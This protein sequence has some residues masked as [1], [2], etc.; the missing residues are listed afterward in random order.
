MRSACVST[1]VSVLV[2]STANAAPPLPTG[3]HPRV[4]L[5]PGTVAAWQAMEADA[6]SPVGRAIATCEDAA[7]VPA[8]ACPYSDGEYQGFKWVEGLGAC[9]VAYATQGE[10]AQLDTALV[11]F[12]A[13]LNDRDTIGDGEGPG[14]NGGVGIVSQDTGYSMRTHG[15]WAALA[16]DWLYDD[17][18]PS[19]IATART[20][21]SQWIAFHHAPN[22]YQAE[23]PGANY[24]AGHVLAMTLLAVGAA[25]DLNDADGNGTPDNT[26]GTELWT[27]VVDTMWGEVMAGGMGARG[28]LGG[29]DWLEGWQ[30]A[31]LSVQSYA[32]AG[33]ALV[34][35]DVE[36]AWLGEWTSSVLLR[37][38]YGLTPS[39]RMFVGGDTGNSEP[40]LDAN[41]LPLFS[42]L[43]GVTAGEV[44]GWAQAEL[45]RLDL[46]PEN[47]FRLFF[48]NLAV[49]EGATAA[50]ID[51]SQLPR[52]YLAAGAGNF[53]G[54]TGWDTSAAWF[55]SQCKGTM[56]DHQHPNAGN[57]ILSRGADEL[58]VDPGPYGSLST[59][60]GNAPTVSQPHF[61]SSYQPSQGAWGDGIDDN[62]FPLEESTRFLWTKITDSNVQATRCDYLG[63][64]R[65][66]SNESPTL[67]GARRDVVFLPGDGGASLLV[68]DRIDADPAAADQTLLLRFRSLG[69]FT[70][71]GTRAEATVGGS[72]LT[73]RRLVGDATTSIYE[74]PEAD[75]FSGD[76]GKCRAGRFA[77]SEWTVE[78]TADEPYV[79][80]LLDADAAGD[81]QAGITVDTQGEALVAPISRH[82]RYFVVV[83]H[84]GF[85][86]VSSY[87]TA[88]DAATH[89]V[90]DPPSGARVVVTAEPGGDGCNLTLATAAGADGFASEPLVFTLSD[91]CVASEDAPEAAFIA[92]PVDTEPGGG[93]GDGGGGGDSDGGGGDG[94]DTDTTDDSDRRRSQG[95]DGGGCG[96]RGGSGGELVMWLGVALLAFVRPRLRGR[97]R[98]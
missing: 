89:I 57:I 59:L 33:R 70:E 20:R 47:D 48:E 71:T 51:R 67:D 28:A 79:W 6:E 5:D 17:L 66:Q 87:T 24:H 52:G 69:D 42:A 77:A 38:I 3:A 15:V 45:E 19:L 53:Y 55:V 60:T 31:P 93:D 96:C 97:A 16:F 26:A 58:L 64:F 23:Q 85:G 34:E 75:C 54:R 88:A 83:A 39:D 68:V 22:T 86:T 44:K 29:G 14:Y 40:S 41:A 25:E 11:L 49:A 90:L 56:V 72:K 50:A 46:P 74:V 95:V 73:V 36:I 81:P 80:H 27:Y 9:L 12:E 4:W 62:P 76:R 84:S 61:A 8:A 21:F 1:L 7:C 32:L 35:Q 94:D 98:G 92:P 63:Q 10:A 78:V 65:F 13:L 43:S 18:S 37:F 2:S 91:A 82:G 30:Y